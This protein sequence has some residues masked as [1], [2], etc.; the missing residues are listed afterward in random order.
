MMIGLKT[1][2]RVKT[3]RYKATLNGDTSEVQQVFG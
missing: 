3:E 1:E 2:S